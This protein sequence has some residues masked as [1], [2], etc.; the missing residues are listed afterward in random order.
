MDFQVRQKVG[1]TPLSPREIEIARLVAR[2]LCDKEI[3]KQLGLS[4]ATVRF[5]LK[6]LRKK[7]GVSSRVGIAVW[8][9]AHDEQTFTQKATHQK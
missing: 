7:L 8:V 4:R 9:T 3:A 6:N 2:E 1:C 5:H